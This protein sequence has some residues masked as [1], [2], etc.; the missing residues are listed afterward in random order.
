M[1]RVFVFL[2]E[3]RSVDADREFLARA[4]ALVAGRDEV[5]IE[6]V[7][8][9]CGGDHGRPVVAGHGPIEVSL[10]R[11]ADVVA[12]A[13]SLAGPVGVDIESVAAA[14]R[15]PFDDI[16]FGPHERRELRFVDAADAAW[17]RASM[18]TSKEAVLKA[19]G[20]GVVLDPARITV[21]VPRRERERHPEVEDFPGAAGLRLTSFD[22]ALGVVGTVALVSARRRRVRVVRDLA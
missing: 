14:A 4:V 9:R 20:V 16:A 2:G 21:S 5:T 18:W 15:A 7:C 3:R 10:S 22:P 12:V 17:A 13:V 8:G 1:S 6:R 19:I 11:A